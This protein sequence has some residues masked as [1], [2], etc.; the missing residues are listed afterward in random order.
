VSPIHNILLGTLLNRGG[1]RNIVWR[2]HTHEWV[3]TY[4][5]YNISTWFFWNL[6]GARTHFANPPDPRL[7]L[8][9]F[10][11]IIEIDQQNYYSFVDVGSRHAHSVGEQYLP[12]AIGMYN[13]E[14]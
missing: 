9:Y 6:K 3:G 13:D 2:G 4:L 10:I 11:I 14:V 7:L 5:T 1:S 8:K 12:F